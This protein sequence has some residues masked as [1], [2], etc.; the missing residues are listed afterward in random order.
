MAILKGERDEEEVWGV[1][2]RLDVWDVDDDRPQFGTLHDL[3]E[4][5][6]QILGGA[7]RNHGSARGS[8]V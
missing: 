3:V 1:E 2:V 5:L 4:R 8:E 6:A 7:A